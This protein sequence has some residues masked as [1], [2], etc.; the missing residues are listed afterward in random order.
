MRLMKDNS[1]ILSVDQ[2]EPLRNDTGTDIFVETIRVVKPVQQ[3]SDWITERVCLK[4][5]NNGSPIRRR[6]TRR[7]SGHFGR[8]RRILCVCRRQR[9]R[10][11]SEKGFFDLAEET[12]YI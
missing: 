4:S 8:R 6:L 5:K 2:M 1:G 7:L 3:Y 10:A 9:Q 11:H 12:K